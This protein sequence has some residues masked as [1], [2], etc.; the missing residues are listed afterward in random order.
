MI[1]LFLL[2]L[3]IGA[4]VNIVTIAIFYGEREQ[5]DHEDII[6][7]LIIL[8]S[9]PVFVVAMLQDIWDILANKEYGDK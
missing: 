6:V 4:I 7:M 2:Y 5:L 8:I 9:W 1:N 3:L